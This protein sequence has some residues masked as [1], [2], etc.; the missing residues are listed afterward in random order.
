LEEADFPQDLVVNYSL[1]QFKEYIAY[2][3]AHS[4]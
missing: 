4:Q 3:R 1:E 2:N